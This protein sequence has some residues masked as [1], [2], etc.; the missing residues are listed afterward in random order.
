[1]TPPTPPPPD[2]SDPASSRRLLPTPP[3]DASDPA[4]SRR[5][6]PTPPTPPPPDASDPASSRRLRPRLFPARRRDQAPH[7][8]SNLGLRYTI[9]IGERKVLLTIAGIRDIT[10]RRFGFNGRGSFGHTLR[11]PKPVWSPPPVGSV[12]SQI[13]PFVAKNVRLLIGSRESRNSDDESY[14]HRSRAPP[15]SLPDR[16]F[17]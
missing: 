15:A 2:A 9:R 16:L 13:V 14:E 4:S 7:N 8:R 5:L 3:P 17:D 12:T 11:A 1:M 10:R 6:L